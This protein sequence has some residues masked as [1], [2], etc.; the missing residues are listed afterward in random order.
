VERK[1]LRQREHIP[2]HLKCG[3][4]VTVNQFEITIDFL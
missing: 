2:C 1:P 4:F 3:Y